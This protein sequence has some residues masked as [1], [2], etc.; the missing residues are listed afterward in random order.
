MVTSSRQREVGAVGDVGV[1]APG[2]AGVGAVEGARRHV[3][4]VGDD[5]DAEPGA[6]QSD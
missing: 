2:H 5:A 3:L 4:L 6:G 1:A